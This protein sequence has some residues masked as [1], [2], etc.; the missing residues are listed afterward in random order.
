MLC[1][2]ADDDGGSLQRIQLSSHPQC[3]LFAQEIVGGGA[4]I[5]VRYV[6]P[7]QPLVPHH[8]LQDEVLEVPLEPDLAGLQRGDVN[9]HS[10]LVTAYRMDPRHDAWFSACFGFPT[11]L[12]YIGDQRRPVLG[13]FSPKAQQPQPQPQKGWMT[14][15][16]SYVGMAT[17]GGEEEEEEADWI[18][19][20][21]CAPYLVATEASLA[22]VSARLSQGDMDMV[23]F[24]PN[25]VVDGAGQW[26]EDF[27]AEISVGG[28]PAVALTKM[29]N[30]CSSINVDY[31]TGRLAE[32]ERGVVLKKLMA[33]RRVDPGAKWSPIFGRYGFLAP[34]AEGAGI[35][36]GDEV[37]VTKRT[38]DR[39]VWDWPMGKAAAPVRYAQ[40]V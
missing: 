37:L 6:A 16:S 34:G 10:S 14:T 23:K 21:D 17:A 11:A 31:D 18:N 25:I 39:P 36:V 8:P 26:D 1:R 13:T 22:S 33:D 5:R 15:L 30:R 40:R 12:V 7:S 32:G 19:F 28:R 29:C 4:V 2:V 3:A 27:W 35:A 38:Q 24:R 9:L 20:S